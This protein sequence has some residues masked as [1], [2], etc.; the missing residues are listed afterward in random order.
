MTVPAHAITLARERW[1]EAP[2][3]SHHLT[4]WGRLL[5][6]HRGPLQ[7]ALLALTGARRER[8]RVPAS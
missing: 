6:V 3:G 1:A 8:V 2:G 5:R 4:E 7:L